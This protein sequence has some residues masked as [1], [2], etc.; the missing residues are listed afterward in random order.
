MKALK[1]TVV[2]SLLV[3]VFAQAATVSYDCNIVNGKDMSSLASGT[4]T[5]DS[6]ADIS[7]S[8]TLSFTSESGYLINF[9]ITSSVAF[10]LSTVTYYMTAKENNLAQSV[11]IST[12]DSEVIMENVKMAAQSPDQ[13]IS[14]LVHCQKK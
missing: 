6:D 12:F 3:G 1:F 13:K 4:V 5:F 10:G 2:L 8:N 14:A 7:R 9:G 11:L